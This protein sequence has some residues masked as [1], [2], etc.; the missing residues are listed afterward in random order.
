M[1]QKPSPRS[2]FAKALAMALVFCIALFLVQMVV[3]AHEKG[4]N[5]AACRVCH[6]AHAGSLPAISAFL[7]DPARVVSGCV[8]ES[9]LAFHKKCLVN[10]SPSR[11]PPAG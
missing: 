10:N 2:Y 3:H 8:Q 1:R 7:Q 6:A 11:A 4:H 9:A 5:E